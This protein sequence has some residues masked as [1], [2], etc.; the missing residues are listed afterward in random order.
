MQLKKIHLACGNNIFNDWENYDFINNHEKI[1]FID[2]TKKLPFDSNTINFIYFE[3]A[4]EHFDEVDGYELLKEFF[5]IL[6]KDGI[7]RIITPSL[8]TYIKRF[9]EW[10][11]D[12]LN[13]LHKTQ[14]HNNTQFLNYAFFGENISKG[15]KF[16][17][18]LQSQE[19]GH[20]FLY[21]EKNLTNK[22]KEVGF[23]DIKLCDYRQSQHKNFQNLETRPDYK[24]LIVELTK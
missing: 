4:L 14:F 1:K 23:N 13:H 2:L 9:L 18:G 5:R 8:D 12:S 16:L 22:C 17:N 11:N 3:H 15:I 7:A 21:S 20:K 24:D 6:K 19:V 10:E